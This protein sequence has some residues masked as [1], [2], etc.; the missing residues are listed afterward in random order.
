[1]SS[2]NKDSYISSFTIC[3]FVFLSL[4]L[5]HSVSA[6]LNGNSKSRYS[7]LVPSL[8]PL[9][10][11]LAVSL[12]GDALSQVEKVLWF[13]RGSFTLLFWIYFKYFFLY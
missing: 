2:M 10:M 13:V 4:A 11:M 3:I 9:N 5:L 8:S 1:M 12:F 7:C 6:V